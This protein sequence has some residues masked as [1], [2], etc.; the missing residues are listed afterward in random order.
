MTDFSLFEKEYVHKP[1]IS[2]SGSYVVNLS[3]MNYLRRKYE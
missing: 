1:F 2:G 3:V